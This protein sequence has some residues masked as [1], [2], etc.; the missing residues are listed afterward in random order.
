M[1]TP[2]TGSR[3]GGARKSPAQEIS[4]DFGIKDESLG[5]REKLLPHAEVDRPFIMGQRLQPGF[6]PDQRETEISRRVKIPKENKNI[7][8]VFFS[9][10]MS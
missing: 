10:E 9:S 2:A 7:V 1:P 4:F 3:E 8:A 5:K 6:F